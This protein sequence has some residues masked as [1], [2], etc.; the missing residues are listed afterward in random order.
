M[1]HL[2]Q[3]LPADHMLKQVVQAAGDAGTL[4]LVALFRSGFG[5]VGVYLGGGCKLSAGAAAAQEQRLDGVH[6]DAILRHR[7]ADDVAL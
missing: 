7:F 2:F 3:D 6:D 5:A 4:R 1:A